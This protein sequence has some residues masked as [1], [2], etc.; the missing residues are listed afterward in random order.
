MLEIRMEENM[1][2]K[3]NNNFKTRDKIV[4]IASIIIIV[5]LAIIILGDKMA[6]KKEEETLQELSTSEDLSSNNNVNLDNIYINEV[7]ASGYIELYNNDQVDVDLSN[8]SLYLNGEKIYSFEDNTSIS[9][10]D[11][12]VVETSNTLGQGEHDIISLGDD[13]MSSYLGTRGRYLTIPTLSES[14]SY[15]YTDTNFTATSIMTQTKN[16]NNSKASLIESNNDIDFNIYG[17]YYDN[18]IEL[19]L[20]C[21]EGKTIYYTTD[22]ETP[23]TE[24]T[25]YTGAIQITDASGSDLPLT[26]EVSEQNNDS[27]TSSSSSKGTVIRAIAVDEN[28][29]ASEVY[30]QT[31]YIGQRSSSDVKN[32]ATISITINPEDFSDYFTGIY[33]KGTSYESA[34]ARGLQTSNYANYLNDESREVTVEYFEKSKDKTYEG[35]LSLSVI[36][37]YSVS[38]SQKS[39]LLSSSTSSNWE[40][41]TLNDF[42]GGENNTLTLS[43]N[44]TDNTYKIREY[45]AANLLEDTKV[46]SYNLTPVSVFINGEYWGLYCL[47]QTIDE[48][49]IA[50]TYS[51]DESDVVVATTTGEVSNSEHASYGESYTELVKWISNHDMTDEDNYDYAEARIDMDSY[52]QFMA[53][54]IYLSNAYVDSDTKYVWRTVSNS[55]DGEYN[56]GKWRYVYTPLDGTM[57]NANS[58]GLASATINSYLFEAYTNDEMFMSLL[59]NEE[60]KAKLVAQMQDYA[61][62]YFNNENIEA[63]IDL[64]TDILEK[65]TEYSYKRFIS[66]SSLSTSYSNELDTIRE[67]FET[68]KDYILKYSNEL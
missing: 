54:N 3:K 16:G 26:S 67:F 28:G 37:D 59:E 18:N 40:G 42:F 64:V 48:S 60:F 29:V 41:S 43:T 50:K 65:G 51:L 62:N 63:S 19:T 32:Y 14:Q 36:D 39:L 44:L 21:G 17:G 13:T 49:Y 1:A 52:I 6:Q 23:T 8:L 33:V 11:Y 53:A 15:G 20:S 57:E 2:S 5:L 58:S 46:A 66:S 22:G 27:Y 45:L 31:Y 56:D 47:R 38:T 34:L 30:T 35:N 25:V 9:S 24:S 10:K 61:N 4:L 12:L 55:G 68:R 7:N